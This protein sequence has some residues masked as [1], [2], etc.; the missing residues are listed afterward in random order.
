MKTGISET[1]FIAGAQKI[2]CEV[3]AI[4][5]VFQ[6]ESKGSGYLPSGH[7][8][9]LF[10]PHVFWKELKVVGITPIISDICYPK[11]GEKPYGKESAQP[12]RMEKAALI[13]REAALKSASWGLFQILGTNYK[14]CGCKTLQEFVNKNYKSEEDQFQLFI[15]Y[16]ISTGLDDELRGLD[17][18]SFAR[19]YNGPLYWKNSYDKK[20]KTAY[21]AFKK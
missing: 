6:V 21:L 8:K 7:P 20:L 3:A 15:N 4:R 11:W 14:A 19:Q 2:G 10:E 1:S 16:I 12:G 5:A 17:W 13:H 9:I 18:T